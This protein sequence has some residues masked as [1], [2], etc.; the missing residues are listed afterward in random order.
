MV[1]SG[2]EE[3]SRSMGE[4]FPGRTRL[5]WTRRASKTSGTDCLRL[6]SSGLNQ[7][8]PWVPPKTRVPSGRRQ[9]ARSQ[10]WLPPIPSLSKNW[11]N[12]PTVRS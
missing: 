10:N 11:V 2:Q 7:V 9:E 1:T 4:S 6:I 12:V 5:L 3:S 8:I